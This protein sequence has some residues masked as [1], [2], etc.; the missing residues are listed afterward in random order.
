MEMWL[1]LLTSVINLIVAVI[2]LTAVLLA[3][4]KKKKD[5]LIRES[6]R[7]HGED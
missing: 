2:N 1:I 4:R 5:S 7:I 6:P 3:R